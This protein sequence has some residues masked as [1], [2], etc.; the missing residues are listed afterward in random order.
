MASHKVLPLTVALVEVLLNGVFGRRGDWC[1]GC[2]P[3]RCGSPW[4]PA[5]ILIGHKAHARLKV[6]VTVEGGNVIGAGS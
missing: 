2:L 6:P 3:P 5:L 1:S 4:N